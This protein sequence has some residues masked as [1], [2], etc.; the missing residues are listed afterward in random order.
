MAYSRTEKEVLGVTYVTLD[1]LLQQ[2]DIV[3]LHVPATLAT[4]KLISAEKLALMNPS[5]VLINCA[6]GPMVDSQA[7][8][9]ALHNGTIAGV[10]LD[11]PESEPPFPAEPPCCLL[12]IR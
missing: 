9:D 1:E 4:A 6:L 3:S 10:C 12:R 11:V 8:A 5:A 2:S 7:L